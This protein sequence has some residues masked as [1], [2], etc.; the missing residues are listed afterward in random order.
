MVDD[1]P[2]AGGVVRAAPAKSLR[3]LDD[4]LGRIASRSNA[5]Y[6]LVGTL[7]SNDRVTVERMLVD[8]RPRDCESYERAGTPFEDVLDGTPYVIPFAAASRFP[9]DEMLATLGVEGY[10]GVPLVGEGADG[11][12]GILVLLFRRPIADADAVHEL[13]EREAARVAM[14]LE[15][16][17]LE[18]RLAQSEQRYRALVESSQDGII[19]HRGFDL[20]YVNPAAARLAGYATP[21]ELLELGSVMRLLPPEEQERARQRMAA[22]QRAENVERDYDMVIQRRDGTE[23]RLR[24]LVSQVEWDGAPAYQVAVTDISQRFEIEER[25]QQARRLESIGKLTGGIA[26]DFNNLLA[27]VLGNLE[28]IDDRISDPDTRALLLQATQAAGRGAELSRRLLSFARRQPLKPRAVV[29]EELFAE[30]RTM[31]E[32]T[33]RS[34]VQ[35]VFGNP[36]REPVLADPTQ[37]QTALLNLANNAQ[38]AMSGPGRITISSR[39]VA[40]AQMSR[41]FPETGAKACV[42]IEV[43]DTGSGMSAEVRDRAFE[44]F[45]STKHA[46]HGSGLGLSMVHGFVRQSRGQIELSSREGEGTRVGLY[47]P[48]AEAEPKFS[49]VQAQAETVAM[50]QGRILVVEDEATVREVTV[51]M[52]RSFGYEVFAAED[53]AAA[54]ALLEQE[55]V[56]LLLSDVVL[57]G[58]RGP[59]I[60][61]EVVRRR[62]DLRV[63]FMSGYADVDVFSDFGQRRRVRLLQKPFRRETLRVQVAEVLAEDAVGA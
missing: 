6:V 22:R 4:L 15:R 43:T 8:G 14:E 33:L 35:V 50:G 10:A 1:G 23:A 55:S 38:D 44:P 42:C 41:R 49:E 5:D 19:V 30:T 29:L 7:G 63:M 18:Q 2:S 25:A 60:A 28:L 27:V 24:A 34:E 20:V 58:E 52:L 17:R 47:L 56:D 9:D 13:L 37:L 12:A 46:V 31:L 26:H 57:P 62:P 51:A 16:V 45:F 32:R 59:E 36:A 11:A 48:V 3:F 39:L 61:A 54:R 53:G 40:A 21:A